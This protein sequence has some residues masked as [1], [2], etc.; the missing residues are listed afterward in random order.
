MQ[1]FTPDIKYLE[2]DEVEAIIGAAE[3][4][5]DKAMLAI[6][7]V[8]G[9]RRGEVQFLVR[10]DYNATR[11]LLRVTRLKKRD[12]YWH[13]IPLWTK[14][15]TLLNA[16]LKTRTDH[17]DALFLGRK[18]GQSLAPQGVYYVFL[19]AVKKAGIRITD[20]TD[21]RGNRH[22]SPHRFRHSIAVHQM[23]CGIDIADIQ[24]HLAHSSINTTI[25][26]ARVLTPRKKRNAMLMQASH[27]FAKL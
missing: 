6:L 12:S 5:R 14:A 8:C 18:G 24:E 23:N 9:L 21:G 17:H 3:S 25:V 16:Y 26:Y 19:E 11:G 13:E 15:K 4:P 2:P 27:H 20:K 22:P 7:Y 1:K 10:D